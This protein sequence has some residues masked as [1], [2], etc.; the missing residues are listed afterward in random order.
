[1]TQKFL[2]TPLT[3][4]NYTINHPNCFF[5]SF[6]ENCASLLSQKTR[7]ARSQLEQYVEEITSVAKVFGIMFSAISD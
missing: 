1:M 7:V 4:H 3:R 6:L 2:A 5:H